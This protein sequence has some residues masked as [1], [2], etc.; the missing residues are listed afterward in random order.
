MCHAPSS[1][2]TQVRTAPVSAAYAADSCWIRAAVVRYRE[3]ALADTAAACKSLACLSRI[4]LLLKPTKFLTCSVVCLCAAFAGPPVVCKPAVPG[5]PEVVLPQLLIMNVQLPDYPAPF[6]G[7]NDGRGQSIVYYFQL[8]YGFDSSRM[9][10]REATSQSTGAGVQ[11]RRIACDPR[12]GHVSSS[13]LS[14]LTQPS[15]GRGLLNR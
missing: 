11:R 15:A 4:C 1:F 2:P 9:S 8:R 12:H 10:L 13:G 3:L 6:W 7:T 14:R 5:G